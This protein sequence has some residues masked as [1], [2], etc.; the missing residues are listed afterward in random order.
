MYNFFYIPYLYI[1]KTRLTAKGR[2]LSFVLILVLPP[3]Y[4]AVLLQSSFS[5]IH[6][7]EAILGLLL[8]QNLYELGYIQN[9]AETIKR[10][11]NPTLRLDKNALKYYEDYKNRIYIV[12]LI[13]A[14]VLSIALLIITKYSFDTVVFLIIAYLLIPVYYIYNSIR[15]FGNLFLHFVLTVIKYS[16]IQLIFLDTASIKVF[17]LSL[18]AYPVVNFIDRA[19]TP[20]F[21]L[22]LSRFYRFNEGRLIYYSIIFLLLGFCFYSNYINYLEYA[23]FVFYFL[24]RLAIIIGIVFKTRM[25]NYR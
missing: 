12:R 6:L 14:I 16:A 17:L 23:I 22:G 9:D 2:L 1:N 10:E 20:R 4:F 7:F 13:I 11:V 3:L 8:V 15:N 24:Y 25:R 5:F 21:L 18:L 19:A